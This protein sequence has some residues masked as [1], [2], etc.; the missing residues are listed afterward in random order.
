MPTVLPRQ[1]ALLDHQVKET[2]RVSAHFS[3]QTMSILPRQARDKHREKALS[4][5]ICFRLYSV[6]LVAVVLRVALEIA[7]RS[8]LDC[9]PSS[10]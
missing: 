1:S 9:L 4:T 10:S 3:I 6:W 8:E 2:Q 5:D 7:V